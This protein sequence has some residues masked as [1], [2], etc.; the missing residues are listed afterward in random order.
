[1]SA[2]A[3]EGDTRPSELIETHMS[4]VVLHGERA[5][6]MKKSARYPFV[7]FSRLDA[8]E[9]DARLEL[10]LNRRLAPQ[11]YLDV[12][13]LQWNAGEFRLLGTPSL[14]APG[15][16]VDWVVLMQRLPDDVMLDRLIARGQVERWQIDRL[17]D[18]LVQFY[19]HATVTSMSADEYVANLRNQQRLNG[20]VL[21]DARHGLEMASA[22]LDRLDG[23]LARHSALLR[24][25]VAQ[26][27]VVDGHGDLRPEHVCL[28][29]PPVVI[30]GLTFDARLRQVDPVE[31]VAYLGME[32]ALAG[33]PWIGAAILDRL[34]SAMGDIPPGLAALHAALRAAVRA[35]LMVAHLLDPQ[36][37]TPQRWLPR[38][39]SYLCAASQWLEQAE[40]EE[41]TAGGPA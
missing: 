35:R 1:M 38:A 25:R 7:D 5:L 41:S 16:T 6:K 31:E 11:V 4:W 34:A 3:H 15:Q 27:H 19:R 40:L 8:R 20:A 39:R 33:A 12:L 29:D 23:A 30:D 10:H 24:Q 36:P 37:R 2:E 13:A 18:T 21:L 28:L 17:A 26:G 9:R 32:C 14:P 22:V